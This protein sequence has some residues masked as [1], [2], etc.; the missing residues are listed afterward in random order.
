MKGSIKK[1]DDNKY[2]VVADI[3]RDPVT[4][5]RRQKMMQ[6]RC[7]QKLLPRP[8]ICLKWRP[9]VQNSPKHT[10]RTKELTVGDYMDEWYEATSND[11]RENTK[12]YIGC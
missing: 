3:G 4:N 8:I 11:L 1:L 2:R 12:K 9:A 6:K 10:N 7:W 5:K